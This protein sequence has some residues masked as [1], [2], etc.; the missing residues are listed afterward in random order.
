MVNCLC[1]DGVLVNVFF[2]VC[3]F[4]GLAGQLDLFLRPAGAERTPTAFFEFFVLQIKLQIG[5]RGGEN[6]VAL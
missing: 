3:F 2:R 4:C 1:L 6:L 5:T